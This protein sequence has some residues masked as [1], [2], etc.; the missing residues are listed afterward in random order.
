ML[1]A[2]Y[3][4]K[5]DHDCTTCCSACTAGA[6]DRGAH[7]LR[8][9]SDRQW[10]AGAKCPR[11]KQAS[12]LLH[13][14]EVT[15]AGHTCDIGRAAPY[16]WFHQLSS[17]SMRSEFCLVALAINTCVRHVLC[18]VHQV[19]QL[20]DSWAGLLS[21][22]QFAEF[23]LPYAQSVI[24]GVRA[25][26]PDTPLIFHANGGAFLYSCP[27]TICNQCRPTASSAA[28]SDRPASQEV[29]FTVSATKYVDL[30]SPG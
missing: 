20:F 9:P 19:V 3:G 23:S 11:S 27:G 22:A 29:L 5:E 1:Q 4:N 26:H 25:V 8:L 13:I 2:V 30:Q 10:S 24:D 12:L 28:G 6:L 18:H 14:N 15:I 17:C 16:I 21:P 7:S